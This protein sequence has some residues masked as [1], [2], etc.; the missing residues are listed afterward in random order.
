MNV[1]VFCV[2]V[3]VCEFLSVVSANDDYDND[4]ESSQFEQI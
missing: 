1:N 2:R 3:C 4:F